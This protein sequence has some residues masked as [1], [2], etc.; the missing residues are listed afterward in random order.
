MIKVNL[1][2]ADDKTILFYTDQKIKVSAFVSTIVCWFKIGKRSI[3]DTMICLV[4][5]S[6]DCCNSYAIFEKQSNT[7][8]RSRADKWRY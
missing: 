6:M 2:K 3:L 5:L 1:I 8:F 7:I 4:C